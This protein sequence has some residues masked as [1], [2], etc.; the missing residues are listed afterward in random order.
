MQR[1]FYLFSMSF[2]CLLMF[3]SQAYAFQCVNN[4]AEFQA[5]LNEPPAD[6]DIRLEEGTY[7]IPA[8]TTDHFNVSANHSLQIS[9]GWEAGCSNQ[10]SGNPSLTTLIGGR[11]ETVPA[12][13]ITQSESGGVL[14][15]II[16][17]NASAATFSIHNLTIRSGSTDLSGGGLYFLHTGNSALLVT[18]SLYDI[19]VGNNETETFGAGIEMLDD[20]TERGMFV[21]ISDCIVRDNSVTSATGGKGGISVE[22]HPTDGAKM[23][24]TIISNCQILNNST[25]VLGGGIYIDSGTGGTI[26]V[27]NI[28][29]GNSI[30]DDNGGGVYIINSEGGDI[31]LTN[32]TITGNETTGADPG[33]KDGG[34]LYVDLDLANATSSLDIYNNIIFN[35]TASG[36][37]NDI[38]IASPNPNDITI[39]NNDFN[40]TLTTGYLIDGDDTNLTTAGNKNID[41]DFEDPVNDDYHLLVSSQAIDA[42]ENLAPDLPAT[43]IEGEDRIQDDTVDM[44]A[45]EFP[46]TPGGGGGGT[47]PEVE[48]G[49]GCFIAT[50]ASGSYMADDVMVLR[51]FRDE[52]LLTNP[53]G[54]VFVKLYYAYSPPIADYIA[55]HD[56]FRLLTRTALTPL[57]YTVKNPLAAGS[58][59]MLLGIFL[60]GGLVRKPDDS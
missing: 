34:G 6:N 56:T 32:N 49:E 44:G 23:A 43:D 17:N 39:K 3:G 14:S 59:F 35:N 30:S 54:R 25:G 53:A 16:D 48:G 46:G 55:E 18:V 41:P 27:N 26:L 47:E 21:D 5:A 52:H 57:V 31:T 12:N 7:P 58:V 2:I 10:T 4:S 8:N 29:A 22:V 9:G 36:D 1:S 42:G 15:V 28:I 11:D 45:Y 13:T 60:M 19:I 24:D 33:E 37:G 20:G 51:N 40:D 50:A 38:F